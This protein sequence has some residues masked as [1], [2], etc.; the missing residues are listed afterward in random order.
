MISRADLYE[1]FEGSGIII[2]DLAR[3][4]LATA[5]EKIVG[6]EGQ[7]TRQQL[8]EALTVAGY[9]VCSV[10]R[11]YGDMASSGG[12]S[13][14]LGYRAHS[15]NVSCYVAARKSAQYLTEIHR[16][17]A[18][19]DRVHSALQM[20]YRRLESMP[21]TYDGDYDH[22]HAIEYDLLICIRYDIRII[23]LLNLSHEFLIV[24]RER[25]RN[26]PEGD[27]FNTLLDI[28]EKRVRKCL[29]LL[30]CVFPFIPKKRSPG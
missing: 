28:S 12:R 13:H 24:E 1:S 4:D 8:D 30:A 26:T 5:L 21:R 29:K 16:H 19:V 14:I 17:W 11:S 23:D 9:F 3:E 7:A 2:P 6:T 20:L 25:M 18:N 22:D 15:L 10:Q 27:V